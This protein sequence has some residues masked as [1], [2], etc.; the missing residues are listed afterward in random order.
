MENDTT[1][2]QQPNSNQSRIRSLTRFANK[3]TVVLAVIIGLILVAL[4]YFK[5]TF[6]VATVNGSP[7]SRLSV[8]SQLEKE[9]GK[10]VLDSL[11]T[12]K[13][14]ESEVKKRGIVTTD[15]EINQEIKNIEAS[16]VGQGGT[17]EAALQEQGMTLEGLKKR[18]GTQKAVEK[19]LEDKI[20]VTD[21]EVNT[22]ITDNKVTL[23]KGNESEAK[24][25]ISVQLRNQKLNQEASQWINGIRTEAKIKYYVEY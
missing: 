23:P 4:F 3:K 6:V 11:I 25:Q 19:I 21:E 2:L 24:K 12:E 1:T 15:D 17:L 20:Q 14:I 7:I 9:G 5:G 10:N 13:L 16:I 8:V 18:I 22:Y